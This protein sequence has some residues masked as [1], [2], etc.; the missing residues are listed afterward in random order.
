MHVARS[1][2]AFALLLGVSCGAPA[3]G[4]SAPIEATTQAPPQAPSP[5]DLLQMP[6]SAPSAEVTAV[7][8]GD[9]IEVD[10]GP[11]TEIVRMLGIDT[12][13]KLGG[14]RPAECHGAEATQFTAHVIPVGSTVVLAR[15]T[16]SRDQYGRLLAYVFRASDGLFV[17][18]ALVSAGHATAKFYE[19][20]TSL[21]PQFTRA[22][23]TAERDQLGFWTTCGGANHLLEIAE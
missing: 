1:T 14:P 22:A 18:H 13:E 20:N 5:D 3:T 10:L 12:P 9:T 23:L 15:D 6:A 8:D 2:I 4:S 11:N 17:N 19:P 16:E 7:I 21:R